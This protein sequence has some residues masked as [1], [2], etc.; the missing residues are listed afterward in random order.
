MELPK[1]RIPGLVAGY[2]Y[3]MEEYAKFM[4]GKPLPL[5]GLRDECAQMIERMPEAILGLLHAVLLSFQN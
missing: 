1:A 4:A 2:R 5:L 3:S